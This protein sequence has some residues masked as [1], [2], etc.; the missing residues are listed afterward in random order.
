MKFDYKTMKSFSCMV[1]RE[2]LKILKEYVFKM[3]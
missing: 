1:A 2:A 3:F